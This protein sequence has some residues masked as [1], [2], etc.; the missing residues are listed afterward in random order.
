MLAVAGSAVGLVNIWRFPYIV[1]QNGGAAFILIYLLFLCLI[2]FPVFLSEILIGRKTELG[3][4]G[5]Y[6]KL[7]KRKFWAIP[8]ILTVLTG[9]IVSG[10]YSAVAAWILGYLI[11]AVGGAVS[12]FQSIEQASLHFEGL[13]RNPLWN[14]SYHF[15]FLFICST[16][17]YFG[18]RNGI[19]RSTK[20]MMPL[21]FATLLFLVFKGIS[22]PHAHKAISFLFNPNWSEL[23]PKALL[24]ALGQAFFTLSL[25][26]GTMVTYGSYLGKKDNVFKMG[27]PIIGIDLIVSIFSAIAVFTIAF[28]VNIKPDAGPNL[29]FNT[30]PWAF[31]QLQGGYFLATTFFLLVT[32]AAVTSEISALEPAIAY[33]CDEWGYRR[34]TSVFVCGFGAFL[35]GVPS[36]LAFSTFGGFTFFNLSILD[37]MDFL[38]GSILIPIGGFVAVVMVGWVWGF[39]KAFEH[40]EE[41]SEGMYQRRRWLRPYLSFC[42]KYLSPILILIVFLNAIGIV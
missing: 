10:F 23:T 27:I 20:I 15:L 21:L 9:F 17:L 22:L 16:V 7:G 37:F 28:S 29:L 26:Q 8:G 2:G 36:S 41:G 12:E 18:V 13:V 11:E 30:L 1:G 6:R 19:E 40:L 34:H 32:L 5:A 24:I 35:L 31:S 25:G 38:C 42:I 3:P 4:A 33:M 39:N 14:I